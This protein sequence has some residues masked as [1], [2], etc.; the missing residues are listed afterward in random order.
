MVA[1]PYTQ[2]DSRVR[3]ISR[4]RDIYADVRLNW[5][6]VLALAV[7]LVAWLGVAHLIANFL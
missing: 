1:L 5:R 3:R 2:A 4:P 7:N 6:L